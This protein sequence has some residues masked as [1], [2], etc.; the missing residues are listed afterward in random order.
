MLALGAYL[1]A[2]TPKAGEMLRS[3][4]ESVDRVVE[5]LLRHLCV[6]QLAFLRFAKTDVEVGGVLIKEGDAVGVSLDDV[7]DLGPLATQNL[8]ADEQA[9]MKNLGRNGKRNNPF[10]YV[11]SSPWNNYDLLYHFL[12]LNEIPQGPLLLRDFGIDE[13]KLGH[14][15]HMSHKYKETSQGGLAVNIVAAFLLHSDHK[16]D[17][18]MRGAFLHVMGDLLGSVM[19]I[20]A[21]PATP[22]PQTRTLAG[23]TL[24]AAVTCPVKRPPNSW[25]DSTTAR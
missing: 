25:A 13:N 7:K 12:E 10:F 8:S 2:T 3:D 16:H 1:I 4:P 14:S 11:S 9:R 19:A 21:R 6:V 20:A 22:A 17:L 15:D 5:E 18:N 24:P 23:G